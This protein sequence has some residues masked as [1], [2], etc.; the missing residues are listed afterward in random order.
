[1]NDYIII[2]ELGAIHAYI[3]ADT[4]E[5]AKEMEIKVKPFLRKE[6]IYAIEEKTYKLITK[7]KK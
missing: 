7:S 4:Q 2:D 3:K 5:Q 1:M 6:D